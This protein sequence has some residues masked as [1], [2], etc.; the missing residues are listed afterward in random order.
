VTAGLMPWDQKASKGRMLAACESRRQ[1]DRGVRQG[2][3][4]ALARDILTGSAE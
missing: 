1:A 4:Q 2:G 3:G